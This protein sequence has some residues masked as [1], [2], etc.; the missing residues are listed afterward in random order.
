MKF[1]SCFNIFEEDEPLEQPLPV[2]DIDLF[3]EEVDIVVDEEFEQENEQLRNQI[4]KQLNTNADDII[5]R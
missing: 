2:E 1:R 4:S 5:I 3:E